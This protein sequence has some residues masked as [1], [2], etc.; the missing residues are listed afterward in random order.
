MVHGSLVSWW[1]SA[2]AG[3]VGLSGVCSPDGLTKRVAVWAASRQHGGGLRAMG[4]QQ[5][6]WARFEVAN[7][8]P[9]VFTASPDR[10]IGV[11]VRFGRVRRRYLGLGPGSVG[12]PDLA[13]FI[14]AAL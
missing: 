14:G 9:E 1:A 11:D 2:C 10:I 8:H 4:D 6:R 7:P 5:P 13:P 12:R 3:K